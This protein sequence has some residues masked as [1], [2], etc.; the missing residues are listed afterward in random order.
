MG[1]LERAATSLRESQTVRLL[2]VGA[3]VLLLLIPVAM[4]SHLIEE[5]QQRR[6]SAVAEVSSSWGGEQAIS[7]PAL[8]V[9]FTRRWMER[10]A[11]GETVVRESERTAVF[12]PERLEVRGRMEAETLSRGIFSVPVYRLGAVVEGEFAGPDVGALGADVAAVHWARARLVVG[13]SDVRAI[14]EAT[15]V[16]WNGKEAAFRPGT[17][18]FGEGSGGI[19]AAVAVPEGGQGAERLTFSFPLS[20]NG[21][22]SLR[23]A[24]FGQVTVLELESDFP[25]PSF[26]GAWL[27]T[28]RSVTDEGFRARWSIPFLGR[29]YPQAWVSGEGSVPAIEASRFGVELV[30]TVDHYRMARRSVK[31]AVMF[32]FLTFAAV[33]LMEVLAGV[34][35]HPIQYLLLGAALCVFY[36]LELSLSE[37]LG[38]PVAYGLAS[39]AV[40]GMVASYSR[41]VLRRG[42]RAAVVGSGV[43][44]LYV[45]LY[46]LLMN[47]D[48]ALLIGS[49]GLFL[50]L[51]GIMYAT[52][53]VDWFAVGRRAQGAG[54]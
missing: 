22:R 45:Y 42:A 16:T 54:G 17:A 41:A 5:R 21:S 31:Y 30:S 29:N 15:A 35:V 39:L 47:E 19:H 28:E 49:V 46:I 24:P 36:L 37:H 12:L 10:G 44:A 2:V 43:A 52:R 38:F 6:E 27:P 48:F 18:G 13:I 3:L 50:V 53:G 9:P 26:Q 51:G 32:L 1:D 8:V 23:V 40:I 14:Q 4:I 34:R 25:A 7:G 20:L 11:E 33:W